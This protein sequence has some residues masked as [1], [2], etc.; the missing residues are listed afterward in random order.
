MSLRGKVVI[1]TGGA[2][3]V[4][5]YVARSFAAE[6]AHLA[7]AD[8]A[9]MAT[10]VSEAEA[11]GAEVLPVETDVT[12]ETQVRSMVDQVYRRWGRVNVLIN[13]AGIVT[14]FHVGSPRWPRIRDMPREFFQKVVDTNLIGTYLC[15]KHVLPYMESLNEGHIINFGQGSTSEA[16]N[17][18]ESARPGNLGS[19]V[20]SVSKIA[21]RAFTRGVAEEERDFNICIMS[22]GPGSSG[23]AG[24]RVGP[25]GVGGIVTEDSPEWAREAGLSR[26]VDTVGNRYVVAAEAPMEFSGHQVIVRDGKVEVSPV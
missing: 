15:T 11:L 17:A 19:C 16:P 14:H 22:M 7:I 2:Q 18:A 8:I 20:Y 4:G 6:G 23:L 9:P 26:G 5:R 24:P 13:D 12:N 21:I 1:V 25:G 3:G 10:I